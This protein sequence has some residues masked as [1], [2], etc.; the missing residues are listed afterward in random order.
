M[1]QA[2]R[3]F[4]T[5]SQSDGGPR[6]DGKP[7]FIEVIQETV[8]GRKQDYRSGTMVADT[9]NGKIKPT[10]LSPADEYSILK[11][12]KDWQAANG[13]SIAVDVGPAL[14][15]T[16]L[17]IAM[18]QS[19][20]RALGCWP[21]AEASCT[22]ERLRAL[23]RSPDGWGAAG[24]T[25]WGKF[26]LGYGYVGESSPGTSGAILM[27]LIGSGKMAELTTAD[28]GVTTGCGE[29]L[30]DI[31]QAKVHSGTTSQFLLDQMASGGSEYLDA[32]V[33]FESDLIGANQ[34]RGR[35]FREPVVAV[36]PQDG[37]IVVGHPFTILTG[38]PWVTE[39]QAA[40]ARVFQ[41]FLLS[42]ERQR[43]LLQAG[44]RPADPNVV[45][46]SP[47][48]VLNGA[49]P[50]AQLVPLEVPDGA[51]IDQI[52]E[53]WHRVKKHAV[54]VLVF[55]KSG[56]MGGQKITTA[57]RGAQQ[58]VRSMDRDDRLVWIPFDT[59]VHSAVEGSAELL[60][61]RI[62]TT[63]A[64][65]ETALYDGVLAAF[66]HVQAVRQTY[67]DSRLYGIV[68]L[69]DGK[70]NRSRATLSTLEQA[71]K[72]EESDPTGVQIHTIAIGDDAD[73]PVLRR[74]ATAAHGRFWKGQTV[75]DTVAVY[76]S[77]A[78]YY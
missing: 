62:A 35:D 72:P 56:S 19:R 48:D 36:Y 49:N 58:F 51:V 63:P 13:K 26:K 59:T 38:T 61:E 16:P 17:V 20:A 69:S 27:C 9:L 39:E 29:F 15:R 71:L 30:A 42:P 46:G 21:D 65:G 57:I 70:D 23:A 74:I 66:A 52:T 76:R 44:L 7:I 77:I 75:G 8:D 5:A 73:E 54:V 43:A 31:E 25:D 78:T 32:V 3:D 12:R 6:H 34:N 50:R 68:V 2:V 11:L 40:A 60:I 33:V 67:G 64:S 22:W 18:W 41:A 47:I 28:V 1:H 24:R 53:V 55:D 4:N 14:A 37:T 10:V 45:I